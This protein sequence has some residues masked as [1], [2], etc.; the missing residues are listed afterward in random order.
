MLVLNV[1]AIKKSLRKLNEMLLLK[2]KPMPL[3][4]L[5]VYQN[6]LSKNLN[7]I[8]WFGFM[9]SCHNILAMLGDVKPHCVVVLVFCSC[10]ET[11]R[12]FC[13]NDLARE[14]LLSRWTKVRTSWI[15]L[16]RY[17]L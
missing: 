9:I 15:V 8:N 13:V 17:L 12:M 14:V 1:F 16:N 10:F 5:R 11:N 6:L 3:L 4:F 2:I 7:K